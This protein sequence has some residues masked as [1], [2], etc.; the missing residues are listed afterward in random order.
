MTVATVRQSLIDLTTFLSQ[1]DASKSIES[2]LQKLIDFLEPHAKKQFGAFI[3]SA[4][5]ATDVAASWTGTKVGAILLP[6]DAFCE[7]MG[8][9][10]GRTGKP[11][12]ELQMLSDFLSDF[13]NADLAA[14][15][16][17]AST[18]LAPKPKATAAKPKAKRLTAEELQALLERCSRDLPTAMGNEPEFDRIFEV[19]VSE[20]AIKKADVIRMARAVG[21]T[22]N[23]K[24]RDA[25]LDAIRNVHLAKMGFNLKLKSM[26]GRTAA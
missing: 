25:A 19:I 16:E 8:S 7:L 10:A 1:V 24:S 3:K 14:F 15:I 26:G 4:T 11:Y 22:S 21:V 17:A 13:K 18:Q 2:N 9:V 6:L 20:S 23:P 12:K 5:P